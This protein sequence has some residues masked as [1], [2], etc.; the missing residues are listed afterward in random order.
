MR[1][2]NGFSAL[3]LGLLSLTLGGE[4]LAAQGLVIRTG[5]FPAASVPS[6]KRAAPGALEKSA[7]ALLLEQIPEANRAELGLATTIELASGDRVVKIPQVHQGLPVALRGVAV[8]FGANDAAQVISAALE[9]DLPPAVTPQ[10]SAEEAASAASVAAG[11]DL[12]PARAHIAVWPTPDG[13]KLVWALDAPLMAELPYLPVVLVDATTGEVV[14]R[15]NAV[16]S[17]NQANVYPTNPIKSPS[18]NTVS[19]PVGQGQ[20]RLQN[21]LVRSLNCIDT[22]KTKKFNVM[23]ET[24]DIHICELLQIAAP[25]GGDYLSIAP[26]AD[27]AAD[28]AFSELSMFYHVNRAYSFFRAYQPSLVVDQSAIPTVSNLR[29]PAGLLPFDRDK[30]KD[31]K[32]PLVPVSNALFAPSNTIFGTL[33]GINGGAMFF[34]QGPTRDYS[35]DGD[36]VYHEFTHAVVNVTLKL[37]PTPHIDEYGVS[38]SPGGMNEAL[39]DFFSS[40]IA[41]DPDVAEYAVKDL[42]GKLS[43]LRSLANPDAC[44]TAIGGEVHQDATLFSGSLWDARKTLSSG[45][46][47][48]F[49]RAVFK[50]MNSSMTGDLAYEDLAKLILIAIEA[51]PLGKPVADALSNAF[52]MRGLLPKCT[53]VLE[54]TGEQLSGPKDLAGLWFAPGTLTTGVKTKTG[55]YSPGVVQVHQKL[56]ENPTKLTVKFTRVE[57]GGGLG[58]GGAPFAP[59]LLVRFGAE[60][61]KFTYQPPDATADV[62]LVDPMKSGTEYTAT[63]DIPSGAKDVYV[64]IGSTGTVDGAYTALKLTAEAVVVDTSSSSSGAGGSGPNDNPESE[65]I[66]GCGCALPGQ[67]TDRAGAAIAAIAALGLLAARRRR[68]A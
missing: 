10:I 64:M 12:D 61:I 57:I 39:A 40:A 45:Q 31:P 36:V 43:A 68:Q 32:L 17:L 42:D 29:L 65:E 35:Y 11:I 59:K 26:A 24:I 23:G 41:G 48:D 50:A 49:D 18:L 22:N 38:Y 54:S 53:R 51:S 56:P 55:G 58:A 37:V 30:L 7:K 62:V 28:D 60:P 8:T 2:S 44:P 27:T 5:P 67:E 4:A 47:A 20:S 13:A 3:S 66:G 16:T 46:Q 6:S 1:L 63:V 14:L 9:E 34:G 52:T 33:F 21:D 15:Y 19:L 25:T